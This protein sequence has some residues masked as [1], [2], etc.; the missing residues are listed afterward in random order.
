MI[1]VTGATGQLGAAVMERLLQRTDATDIAALV[2]GPGKAAELEAGGVSIR[3]G[4]YDDTQ[5]LEKAMVGV[6]G[7]CSSPAPIPTSGSSNTR[8]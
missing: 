4:D 2:R 8:T 1:L 3:R 7:C 5:A 6:D